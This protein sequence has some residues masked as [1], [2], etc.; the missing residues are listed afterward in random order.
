[1][2]VRNILDGTIQIEG[3]GGSE[4]PDNPE[5]ETLT[6]TEGI[7]TASLTLAGTEVLKQTDA[8]NNQSIAVTYSDDTQDSLTT[9]V[10]S[11]VCNIN[12]EQHMLTCQFS[13]SSLAQPIKQMI[14]PTGLDFTG[15]QTVSTNTTVALINANVMLLG[16]VRIYVDGT[17][18]FAKVV[19]SETPSYASIKIKIN[20]V[21]I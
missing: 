17:T 10:H 20:M 16:M 1:M 9:Q 18:L 5:V 3:G 11:K 13:L 19:F 4:M 15:R 21:Y 12:A 6:A 8:D 2:S 7:T 14:I